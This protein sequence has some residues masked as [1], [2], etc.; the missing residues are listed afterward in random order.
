M[1]LKKEN[2]KV[3][4]MVGEMDYMKANDMVGPKENWKAQLSEKQRV[5]S[6]ASQQAEMTG[7]PTVVWKV[8]MMEYSMDVQTVEW[9]A[10]LTD[11]K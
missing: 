9:M 3:A 2:E 5:A 1:E 6:M 8:L 10:V 7:A 11:K 4:L